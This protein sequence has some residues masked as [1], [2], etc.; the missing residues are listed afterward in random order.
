MIETKNFFHLSC[1]VVKKVLSSSELHITSELEVFNAAEHWIGFNADER[2]KFAK[3]LLQT[4][5]LPLLSDAALQ[6]LLLE[7]SLICNNYECRSAVE[8]VLL[9]RKSVC[10]YRHSRNV[11]HR[12]CSQ[13][14]FDV[15]LSSRRTE[16]KKVAC[17]NFQN[18][19]VGYPVAENE[20]FYRAVV[21]GRNIYAIVRKQMTSEKKE[22]VIKLHVDGAWKTVATTKYR[23]RFCVCNFMKNIFIIGG[24]YKRRLMCLSA[25]RYDA[26]SGKTSSVAGTERFDAACAAFDGRIVACGGFVWQEVQRDVF[27]RE[28][29]YTGTSSAEAFDHAAGTWSR[30]PD[31]VKCHYDHSLVAIK[32]KLFVVTNNDWK[33]ECEVF[34]KSSNRFAVIA[35]PLSFRDVW[36]KS[37]PGAIS[38]GKKLVVFGKREKTIVFYDTEKH[39]WYE[40]TCGC[41]NTLQYKS[42]V[43]LPQ[44]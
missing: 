2:T 14:L 15:F 40:E 31:M 13:S 34:D 10:D 7:N 37:V 21:V 41:F 38:I 9:H 22:L 17:G 12:Y 29:V 27:Q 25:I 28:S 6:R 24:R 32:S 3:I 33:R 1:D 26:E 36:G 4:V 39:E 23:S 20:R 16:L 18:V 35:S 43:K 8:S 30:M 44:I 5:R 42:C 11:E 19:K